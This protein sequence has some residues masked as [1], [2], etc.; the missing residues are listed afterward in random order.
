LNSGVL[1]SNDR[2]VTK[3]VGRY[4]LPGILAQLGVK[5]GNIINTVIIGHLLGTDGLAIMSLLAPLELAMMSVGSLICVA[6]AVHAGYAA[7]RNQDAS[8][9]YSVSFFTVIAAGA[10]LSAFGIIFAPN[11]AA[12]LGANSEQLPVV[13]DSIRAMLSGGVFMTAV[14]LPLNFLKV[15]GLPS[16]TMN[17]LFIMSGTNIVF[18]FYFAAV[19]HMGVPGAMLGTAVSY[20][21]AF[22]YG[23]IAFHRAGS[24]IKLRF[25]PSDFSG[26]AREIISGVPSALNNIMRSV[27]ALCVNL[28]IITFLSDRAAEMMSAFAVL[29]SV[30]GIINAFVFGISQSTLQIAGIAYSEKDFKTVKTA[31][32]NIFI[33][34]NIIVGALSALLIIFHNLIPGLFGAGNSPDAALACVFAGCYA[35]LY[36]CNNIMTNFFSAVRR[37]LPAI[38]IVT[39]RLSVFMLLPT[40]FFIAAG[41]GGIS[42]WAGFLCAEI[43]A[44]VSIFT[45]AAIKRRKN[46]NLSK[47]LLLDSKEIEDI[48]ALN[49][50]VQ[51]TADSAAKASEKIADFLEEDGLLP[52][53]KIMHL[54][55]AV[56]EIVILV[57]V[58][59]GLSV[60]D[61]IDVRIFTGL[62]DRFFMRFS[63]GGRDFNPI[64]YCAKHKDD[65][66]D[67]D[68]LGMNLIM[69]LTKNAVYNRMLG[70]NNIIL[71]I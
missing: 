24:G 9:R 22:T 6:G 68:T 1:V 53:K 37:N 15:I 26:K 17:V 8:D 32:K 64:T 27:L 25:R 55:M 13:T 56:E 51:N 58:H 21:A 62:G 7:A 60:E 11:L 5:I 41:M 57:G 34:G 43:I 10:V 61:F 59:A 38:V 50:S 45:Y 39:L 18:A 48:S 29:N 28:I 12:L 47:Y 3:I 19:L 65:E 67:S 14:Y 49:F 4:I 20:A 71:E 46:P 69:R 63:Y 40:L 31:I 35:N 66:D 16:K 2:L 33:R 54:S 36:L 30:M 44:F 23:Q 52:P 70:V 42:V